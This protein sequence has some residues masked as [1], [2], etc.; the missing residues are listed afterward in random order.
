M[1]RPVLIFA[2]AAALSACGGEPPAAPVEAPATTP[3]DEAPAAAMPAYVGQWAATP[4]LCSDGAWT[5]RHDGLSTAGEVSC[6]FDGVAAL[7]DGFEIAA[8]CTAQAPPQSHRLN[9]SLGADGQ[10][11]RVRGGPFDDPPVLSRCP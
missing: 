7:D 6:R 10:T 2:L 9:L 5:F 11:M 3:Q 1:I 8:T 4:A